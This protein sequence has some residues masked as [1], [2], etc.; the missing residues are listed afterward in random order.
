MRKLVQMAM[1]AAMICSPVF[2]SSCSDDNEETPLQVP[3]LTVE[4]SDLTLSV[5]DTETRVA[6]TNSDAEISYA[7]SDESVATVDETGLITAV[8]EGET[9][10]TVSVAATA[11]YEAA[12]V[13]FRV[14]V[15]AATLLLNNVTPAN[16]GWVVNH[17]GEVYP[18]GSDIDGP[19]AM[20]AY[21]DD[22]VVYGLALNDLSGSYSQSGGAAAIYDWDNDYD[23][24]LGYWA[25]PSMDQFKRIFDAC[26]GTPYSDAALAEGQTFDS[27]NLNA[28]LVAAGGTRLE[29][30]RWTTSWRT[31]WEGQ[32]AY[33]I[34]FY[35]GSTSTIIH[36][37]RVAQT[38][39]VR[40]I[41]I[42]Y[43]N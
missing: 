31:D 10:I 14:I 19:C 8:G 37:N 2:I 27:G 18:A 7:S 5:G 11:Q 29:S 16:I 25:L 9:V 3:T 41:Y 35:A 38:F 36:W 20:I 42:Y 23:I 32:F 30:A 1:A 6:T 43:F 21:V 22:N 15:E 33:Y 34:H 17:A 40:P 4:V 13:S 24:G 12:E 26:G 28:M 39:K